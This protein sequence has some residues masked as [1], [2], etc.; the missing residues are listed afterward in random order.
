MLLNVVVYIQISLFL[1]YS[2][3]LYILQFCSVNVFTVY[4]HSC[5]NYFVKTTD[6][7]YSVPLSLILY[8]YINT[9]SVNCLQSFILTRAI[10]IIHEACILRV[11]PLSRGPHG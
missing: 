7:F 2:F 6:L 5:Q 1:N 9:T 4:N 11:D 8:L 10:A 3:I